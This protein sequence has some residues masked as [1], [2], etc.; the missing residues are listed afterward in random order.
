VDVTSVVFVLGQSVIDATI[1]GTTVVRA[2][3]VTIAV[4]M[5]DIDAAML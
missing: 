3:L 1:V 5:I 4:G 2:K